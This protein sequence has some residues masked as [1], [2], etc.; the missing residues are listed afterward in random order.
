MDN[1]CMPKK[2]PSYAGQVLNELVDKNPDIT[3][4]QVAKGAGIDYICTL[5]VC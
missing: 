3:F 1:L 2:Q 4:Y 5:F